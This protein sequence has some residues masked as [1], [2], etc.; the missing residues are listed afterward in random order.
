MHVEVDHGGA[1]DAVFALRVTCGNR[2]VVEKA[3]PHRLGYFGVMA[4]WADRDERVIMGTRHHSVGRGNRAADAA[5]HSL[6][7]AW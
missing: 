3:E 7:G 4:G 5:H 1:A 6:P 2:G